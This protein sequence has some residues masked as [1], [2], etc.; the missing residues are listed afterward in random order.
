MF[1][2]LKV[3]KKH[4]T[5]GTTKDVLV[6]GNLTSKVTRMIGQ[7]K[8]AKISSRAGLVEKWNN[9]N[10]YFLMDALMLWLDEPG[11]QMLKNKLWPPH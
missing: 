5:N 7:L 6:K 9:D 8:N 4:I 3:L 10:P 1:D 11:K 2:K